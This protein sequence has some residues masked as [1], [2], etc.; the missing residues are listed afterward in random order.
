MTT[1]ETTSPDVPS[2][3]PSGRPRRSISVPA[4]I[5]LAA[6]TIVLSSTVSAVAVGGVFSDVPSDHPFRSEIDWLVDTG[7]S[8]GYADGTFRPEAPVSRQAMAAFLQRSFEL[9]DDID[10]ASWT[11]VRST[12]GTAWTDVP[13]TTAQV[14]IPEGTAGQIGA[15]FSAESACSGVGTWC[16]VR[17][18]SRQVG[19]EWYEM[20]PPSGGDLAF[21][22]GGSDGWE[23]HAVE[24]MTSGGAGTY[25]VKVQFKVSHE[26]ASFQ[27]DDALLVAETHLNGGGAP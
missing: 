2:H 4:A 16:S 18:L 27:L 20:G 21:D 9:R 12:A 3:A 15:R 23:S 8:T 5:G 17:L 14:H 7:I 26:G 11:T 13:G 1:N 10:K 19:G 25:E 22:S 24:R 6:A